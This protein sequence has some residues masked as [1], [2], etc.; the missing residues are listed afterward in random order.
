[1][2]TN[3]GSLFYILLLCRI[4]DIIWYVVIVFIL[5]K[6]FLMVFLRNFKFIFNN[7]H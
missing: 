4:I 1:M 2:F 6:V 5:L 7:F 3:S